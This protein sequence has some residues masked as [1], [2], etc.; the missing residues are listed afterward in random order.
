[1]IFNYLRIALDVIEYSMGRDKVMDVVNEELDN[2]VI[3]MEFR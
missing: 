3:I 1:L 2:M